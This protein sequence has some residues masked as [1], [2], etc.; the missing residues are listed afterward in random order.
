MG[1]KILQKEYDNKIVIILPYFESEVKN[2][3]NK[4][5]DLI[6]S[7]FFLNYS[8]IIKPHPV[9]SISDILKIHNG[10]VPKN[11]LFSNDPLTRL[12]DRSSVVI[13]NNSTVLLEIIALGIPVVIIEIKSLTKFSLPA[14]VPDSSW[15]IC[16]S[17]KS[18]EKYLKYFLLLDE[19]NRMKFVNKVRLSKK[20]F[21]KRKQNL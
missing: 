18:L 8:F 14:L 10:S 19:E 5:S 11:F 17:S 6:K 21:L 12:L 3:L 16:Y 2:I 15:K 13:C 7:K 20:G 1:G 4:I 9:H